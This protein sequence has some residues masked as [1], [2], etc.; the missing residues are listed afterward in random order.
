[1]PAPHTIWR[2]IFKLE[3]AHY[4]EIGEGGRNIGT[5]APYWSLRDAAT[6]G[7]ANPLPEGPELATELEALLRDS[8]GQ[9]MVA[10]VPLGAFLS[11]GVD[12]SLIVAL[13]QAQSRRPVRTFTIGFEAAQFDEAPQAK[14]VA[15]HLGTDHTELYVTAQDALDVIPRLPTMWDE[16][17]GDSSQIP[18][19]LVSAMSRRKVTVALSGDGGDELFGGYARYKS[20]LRIWRQIR[21]WPLSIRVPV[22]AQIKRAARSSI[23][24]G[25]LTRVAQVIGSRS[26]E[27]LYELKV[28]RAQDLDLLILGDNDRARRMSHSIPFLARPSEKMLY[29]D[30]VYN[31]PDDILTKVDR[32]AM[33][34]S[35]EV[36]A[37][38][39]DHRLVE[40]AWRLPMSTKLSAAGGKLILK[41]LLRRHLPVGL[42]D[43]PKMGFSVPVE[44][45]L[46]GP[47]R[48]WAEDLLAEGRLSR[49]GL[50]DPVAVRRLWRDFLSG[51]PRHDRVL[52]NLLMFQEWL[53]TA[54]QENRGSCTAAC[55]VPN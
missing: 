46:R 53:H 48:T 40:L 52:W 43:R 10:D 45:W 22:A 5:A 17:F 23:S 31:L 44:S 20:A 36:R 28:S 27:D 8:V 11:G 38:F 13:M 15:A 25:P 1:V 29:R 50:F 30:L 49:Q 42:V 7:S 3:P 33:A 16:P 54:G 12:S 35:L 18:T 47:L 55:P 21:R 14:S 6:E 41:T 2:G 51:K 19:Y 34:I 26:F 9:R 39:L 32:A 24:P 37:P 4:V